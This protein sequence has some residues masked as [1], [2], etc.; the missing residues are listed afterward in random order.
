M[1]ERTF[2][3]DLCRDSLRADD[4]E[5]FGLYWNSHPK[6]W[7]E[8]APRETEHHICATCLSSLQALPRRCGQGYK[9][10][11]GPNCGSDHK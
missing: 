4:A 9:C 6:G 5:L 7:T 11:G 3:C 10:T 1:I 8:K 2:R